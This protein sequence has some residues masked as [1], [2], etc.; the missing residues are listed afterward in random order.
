[1]GA[2]QSQ[3]Q[4]ISN[5]LTEVATK[6]KWKLG[7]IVDV[8]GQCRFIVSNIIPVTSNVIPNSLRIMELVDGIA[9]IYVYS[10]SMIDISIMDEAPAYEIVLKPIDNVVL[11][12][13]RKQ[14]DNT[15]I[16][17]NKSNDELITLE[18]SIP[19]FVNPKRAL[20]TVKKEKCCGGDDK[21]K[22]ECGD[23]CNYDHSY[24]NNHGGNSDNKKSSVKHAKSADG[25]P[26]VVPSDKYPVDHP[27]DNI[28]SDEEYTI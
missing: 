13:G 10:G 5:A 14:V 18:D 11:G 24:K 17:N 27:D 19:N 1:M 4:I 6:T 7:L 22:C 9:Y 3:Y 26:P 2:Q 21:I 28:D 12:G 25:K 16:I 15:N 8:I 23:R 20:L